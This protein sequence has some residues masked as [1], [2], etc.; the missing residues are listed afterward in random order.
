VSFAAADFLVRVIITLACTRR[1]DELAVDD[2]GLGNDFPLFTHPIKH[3]YQTV[4][5]LEQ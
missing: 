3:R 5:R 1:L 4:E 2:T